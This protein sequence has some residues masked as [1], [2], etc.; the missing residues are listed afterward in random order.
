MVSAFLNIGRLQLPSSVI[1]VGGSLSRTALWERE[2]KLV[3]ALEVAG[4]DSMAV[5]LIGYFS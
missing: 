3:Y 5:P 1:E 4:T 2:A